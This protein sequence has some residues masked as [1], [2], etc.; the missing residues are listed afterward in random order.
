MTHLHGNAQV[1]TDGQSLPLAVIFPG[2]SLRVRDSL[3]GHAFSN[4]DFLL[5]DVELVAFFFLHR[6]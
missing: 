3:Q 4:H 5:V 6:F 1:L 2:E